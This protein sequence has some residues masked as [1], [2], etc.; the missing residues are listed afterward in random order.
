MGSRVRLRGAASVRGWLVVGR[1]VDEER[2]GLVGYLFQHP[3][4][5]VTESDFDLFLV[6]ALRGLH[7]LAVWVSVEYGKGGA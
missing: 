5:V 3:H 2:V 1:Y 6:D 4:G 7:K